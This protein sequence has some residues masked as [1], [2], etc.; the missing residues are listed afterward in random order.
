M[1]LRSLKIIKV[2]IKLLWFIRVRKN[3]SSKMLLIFIFL[4]CGLDYVILFVFRHIR[5]LPLNLFFE[6]LKH[7]KRER[8]VFNQK[9]GFYI[10]NLVYF[11]NLKTINAVVSCVQIKLNEE[12]QRKVTPFL[13][14]NKM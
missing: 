4:H 6:K 11:E 5:I 8:I 7:E 2:K 1:R 10:H 14:E 12:V 9:N 13:I 3:V